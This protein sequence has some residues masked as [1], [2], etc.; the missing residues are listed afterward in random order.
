MVTVK[1]YN[2]KVASLLTAGEEIPVHLADAVPA[3]PEPYYNQWVSRTETPTHTYNFCVSPLTPFAVRG[4]TW[5]PGEDSISD[6][7]SRYAPSLETYASSLAGTFGQEQVPFFY[8][9][10][11]A[12]LVDGITAPRI[13]NASSVEFDR[14]PKSLEAIAVQLGRLAAKRR[15]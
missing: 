13:V 2:Q 12:S 8:A 6:D 7:V 5:I 1:Q 15:P 14:W 3:F 11:A 4:V 9:Q 10:P